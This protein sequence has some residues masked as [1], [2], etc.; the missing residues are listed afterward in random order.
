M[1]LVSLR[2]N[3]SKKFSGCP[4]P[5]GYTEKDGKFLYNVPCKSWGCQHCSSVKK[6]KILQI[7]DIRQGGFRYRMI[8]LTEWKNPSNVDNAKSL[9]KH[10]NKLK[11]SLLKHNINITHYLTNRKDKLVLSFIL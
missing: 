11:A 1:V 6:Y 4:N 3:G 10:W 5:V 2:K 9:T 7:F 8:T